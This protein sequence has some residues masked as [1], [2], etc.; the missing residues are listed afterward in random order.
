METTLITEGAR[1]LR[2]R[3]KRTKQTVPEFCAAH[4]V[5]RHQVQR[6]LNGEQTRFDIDFCVAIRE[7]T[8]GEIGVESWL[9]STLQPATEEELGR[10][11]PRHRP[12]EPVEA[13]DSQTAV[14]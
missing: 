2:A 3:L 9:R 11:H 14:G 1:L 8:E 7:A 13:R 12:V 4:G 10:V 5:A 6:A